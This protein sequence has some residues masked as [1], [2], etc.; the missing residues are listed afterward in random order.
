MKSM[1]GYG[2]ARQ[3]AGTTEIS[4]VVKAV[5]G[6]FLDPRFHLPK[7]YFQFEAML[8]KHMGTIFHRGTVD[9]YIHRRCAANLDVE[10][11]IDVAKK[12]VAGYK[13]LAKSLN[14][15]FQ[16]ANIVERLSALPQIFEVR[17]RSS[18]QPAEKKVLLTL[19]RKAVASCEAER[20]RE[21]RSLKIELSQI[22]KALEKLVKKME[23]LRA[24][25]NSGIDDRIKERL[26]RLGLEGSVD[27]AR[28]AQEL[29]IYLDKCDIAEEIARLREHILMCEKYL[30]VKEE[31][32]KKMDFYSQE[33]L[34]EVNTIGSKANYAP[35]TELVIQSKG[36]IEAFKE[37]VQNI[38]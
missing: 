27:P 21:G 11:N 24:E 9:V 10:L 8:K 22:L 32:G 28:F 35:I 16:S 19:F 25:V 23:A 33:L 17:D 26:R 7:E 12:W 14:V 38:E 30:S 36:L 2:E 3:K 34:R 20:V 5:N 37:Q 18:V 6:R 31:Q 4:V 29:V 1:T 13:I 15:P